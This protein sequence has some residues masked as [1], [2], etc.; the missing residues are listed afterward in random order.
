MSKLMSMM[1]NMMKDEKGQ[2]LIE[3]ILVL[4]IVVLAIVAI[5]LVSGIA[6]NIDTA[7]GKIATALLG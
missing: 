4:V 5:Y 1:K 7:L 3:Y 6:D 2:T